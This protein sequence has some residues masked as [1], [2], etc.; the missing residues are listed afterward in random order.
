M[1]LPR[2]QSGIAFAKKLRR[3]MSPPEQAMWKLLRARRLQGWKFTRQVPIG[4]FVLDFA[5]RRERLAIELDG[6]THVGREDYDQRRTGF[7]EAEGWQVIRFNN[8]DVLR[9][10]EGVMAMV[11]QVLSELPPSPQP[12]PRRGEGA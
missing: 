9:N 2:D 12:S 10:P 7:L 3:E 8:S 11:L 6:E 4:P 1:R 5:A